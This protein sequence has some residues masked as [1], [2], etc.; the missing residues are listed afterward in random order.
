MSW[1]CGVWRA[2]RRC[3]RDDVSHCE[4]R[5]RARRAGVRS[6]WLR[7]GVPP[8]NVFSAPCREAAGT[9]ERVVAHDALWCARRVKSLPWR[10][11]MTTNTSLRYYDAREGDWRVCVPRQVLECNA[12]LSLSASS[13]RR[14]VACGVRCPSPRL[15]R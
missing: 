10:K 4:A 1:R 7:H 9:E 5:E 14:L 11:D 6:C 2:E 3:H 12:P 13:L 8:K 15:L